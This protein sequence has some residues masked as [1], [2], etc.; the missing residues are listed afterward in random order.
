M[1]AGTKKFGG[2]ITFSRPKFSN[3]KA[4]N[5]G[6]KGDFDAGLDD[7]DDSGNKKKENRRAGGNDQREFINL[8]SGARNPGQQPER[9]EQKERREAVKPTFKGKLN[10]QGTGNQANEENSGV[11]KDYDFRSVYK[12]PF[13]EGD[14]KRERR[15]GDNNRGGR[16]GRKQ[17]DR[18]HDF[19][20]KDQNSDDDDEFQVVAKKQRKVKKFNND[21]DSEENPRRGDGGGFSR[22]GFPQRTQGNSEMIRGA[23]VERGGNRGGRG[24]F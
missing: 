12:K 17:R 20:R 24:G 6:N 7:L 3:K 14:E 4:G 21:S 23:R 5:F 9:E 16:G 1:A 13:E 2:D 8:S 18:G 10:L 19:G 11:V 15:D 22:G